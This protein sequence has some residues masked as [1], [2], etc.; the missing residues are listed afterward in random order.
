MRWYF[1]LN[2]PGLV[3]LGEPAIVAVNSCL[4]NTSLEPHFIYSGP[5]NAFS[6]YMERKGV[7]VHYRKPSFLADILAAKP[8][9]GF[10]IHSATGAYLRY[11]IANIDTSDE[12]ALYTDAD[13]IF[14]QDMPDFQT[15][16]LLAAAPEYAVSV[17]PPKAVHTVLNSGVMLLNLK[18][19]R[20]A[21]P[22][23]L[24][25][26]RENDFYFHGRGGF[27]DQGALNVH[28]AGR[29]GILPQ[30]M[31]WR[32]F[33]SDQSEPT[34]VHFHGTKPYEV[35]ALEMGEDVREVCRVLFLL[36][37]S[38]YAEAMRRYRLYIDHSGVAA[39]LQSAPSAKL[40]WLGA[41]CDF[42]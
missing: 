7:T 40:A 31:N 5:R 6:E 38:S 15:P 9:P 26:C 27:Y 8:Q 34:I 11:E 41:A 2:E 35:M 12:V 36:A 39:L 20:E 10:S 28:L 32:P 22:G 42:R 30:H 24:Q 16:E 33:A 21:M 23:L 14:C 3:G 19:Y 37:P 13:V 29:W 1:C 4:K 18:A 17:T 25:C